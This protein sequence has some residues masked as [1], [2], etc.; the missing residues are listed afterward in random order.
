[1]TD[2]RLTGRQQQTGSER[3]TGTKR[4]TQTDR[5]P[6]P[7]A[8]V[9]IIGAGLAGTFLAYS[10]ASRDHDVV[11]LEAGKRFD[12]DEE[13]RTAEQLEQAVRPDVSHAD[14]WGMF[15]S[16][17]AFTNDV[18][19][20]IPFDLNNRRV[21]AVGGTSLAWN[22][23]VMRFPEKD[24]EMQSR[25]GLAMDWPI[26]YDDLRPYYAQAEQEMGVA[27]EAGPMSPPRENPFPMEPFPLSEPD[28][29]YV[30][31]CGELGINIQ[32]IPHARNTTEYDGRSVCEGY[33]TCSP[34]CPTGARYDASVHIR[35]AEAEGAR[36][37]DRVPVLSLEHD[38]AG[39][40]VTAAVYATPDGERHR[41][42]ATHFVVAC[43][44]VETPRLLLLSDSDEYPDG[45]AN[46]S[47]AVGRY[48]Q[49]K[50]YINTR[51]QLDEPIQPTQTGFDTTMSHEFYEPEDASTGS[52]WLVFRNDDP[53]PVVHRALRPSPLTEI[54][55][56]PWGDDLLGQLRDADPAGFSNLRISAYLEQLPEEDNRVTLDESRTDMYGNPVPKVEFSFTERTERTMERAQEVHREIFEGMGLEVTSQDDALERLSTD[57]KGTTRMGD[58]PD[59]SVVNGQGQTHDLRNLWLSG[60]SVFTTGGA[61]EPGLTVVALALKTADHIH[62]TLQ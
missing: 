8:D 40:E 58:D 44:P 22:G 14:M 30:E 33:G 16:R 7:G 54:S 31:A 49:A 61:V 47:G 6:S 10:L 53:V 1:M 36:I 11:V 18:P 32:R 48:F 27:G 15:E 24:F 4:L 37:I 43:G 3:L 19:S 28:E 60:P 2:R 29:L 21:K 25:Y 9:C 35:R 13:G 45:L 5:T 42:E 39:E 59:E 55:G 50:T 38:D 51:A 57:H 52:I 17:D 23:T 41:Q 62:D 46:T 12:F 56:N 34:F 26:S 20:H